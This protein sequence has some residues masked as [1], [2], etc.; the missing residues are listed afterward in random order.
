[1]Q[2]AALDQERDP[3]GEPRGS[4]ARHEL[5]EGPRP[6]RAQ[7]HVER[8]VKACADADAATCAFRLADQDLG[9]ERRRVRTGL[10]RLGEARR[11]IVGDRH[12]APAGRGR[13]SAVHHAAHEP[14]RVLFRQPAALDPGL[15]EHRGDG[16]EQ[17]LVPRPQA[18]QRE[19][20]AL[21]F[22]GIRQPV[23]QAL[24]EPLAV[25]LQTVARQHARPRPAG[26]H[27]GLGGDEGAEPP[28]P[29]GQQVVEIEPK[30]AGLS[31]RGGGVRF[32][33]RR[34]LVRRALEHDV[35]RMAGKGE[36]GIEPERRDLDEAVQLV[37]AH[38]RA[39]AVEAH[40]RD[41]RPVMAD[42]D[43]AAFEGNR[44]LGRQKTLQRLA[45]ERPAQ[46]LQVVR[47]GG[48]GEGHGAS[49]S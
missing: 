10:R 46:A 26:Q 37:G 42:Q 24:A 41:Q 47:G 22:A 2:A 29:L 32:G 38:H 6:A 7:A 45:P 44:G 15:R 28:R 11:R 31:P 20:R 4:Q 49:A 39:G 21:R 40:E 1:M 35:E 34:R 9:A 33:E 13:G 43:A 30:P 16:V 19:V 36:G 17:R 23:A 27:Q 14:E 3:A 48:E 8:A 12:R 25:A 18:L 5:R